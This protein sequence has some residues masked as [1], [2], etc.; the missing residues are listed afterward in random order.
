MRTRIA[1]G[2][3]L[4]CVAG[5]ALSA[6]PGPVAAEKLKVC[7]T[8]NIPADVRAQSVEFRSTGR[9]GSTRTL[10]GNVF[11][12][13]EVFAATTTAGPPKKKQVRAVLQ[14]ESPKDL[15]G[16]AYL[17]RES[18]VAAVDGTYFY[19]PSLGKPRKIS[20]AS[21]AGS[22]L[23]TDF[24][25]QEFKMILNSFDG[26][27]TTLESTDKLDG[28]DVFVANFKPDDQEAAAGII[29]GWIDQQ[30]CVPLKLDFYKGEKLN[31]QAV[32][33][34]DDVRAARGIW[35]PVEVDMKDLGAG[36]HTVLHATLVERPVAVPPAV[37]EPET[38]FTV[39]KP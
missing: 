20:G 12:S 18:G 34:P 13:Q 19:L 3:A 9:D 28:R 37:F 29:R 39:V 22:L 25:F 35:F 21:A 4:L 16:A 33:K 1:S 36:T 31:K 6:D 32:V 30:T 11:A 23:G 8:S 24:S 14:V 17:V 38:F 2:L 27:T 15:A 10:N 5:T 26:M 7:L